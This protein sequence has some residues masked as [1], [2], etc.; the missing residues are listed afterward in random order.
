[1]KIAVTMM[2]DDEDEDFREDHRDNLH[3]EGH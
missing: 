2:I 3:Y 1:M